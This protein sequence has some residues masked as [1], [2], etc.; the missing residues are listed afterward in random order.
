[1]QFK[2]IAH[3]AI[4]MLLAGCVFILQASD[5]AAQSDVSLSHRVTVALVEA[6]PLRA[7]TSYAAAVLRHSTG[8][9]PRD[10]ILL[11]RDQASG[12]AL[13]AAVRVLL[14]HRALRVNDLKDKRG[15]AVNQLVLAVRQTDPPPE[16]GR[17]MIPLAQQVVDSLRRADVR[18]I[19]GVGSVRAVDFTLPRA[20]R[21]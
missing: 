7:T 6:L 21:R 19:K 12:A 16:W 8:P 3:V 9:Q 2:S 5:A 11:R 4:R 10:V 13:D 14:H 18:A 17:R 15:V 20:P 1:M